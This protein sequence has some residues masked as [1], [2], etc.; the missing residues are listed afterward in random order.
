MSD[1]DLKAR[2]DELREADVRRTPRFE[3]VLARRRP[4]S[5]AWVLIPVGGLALVVALLLLFL[6]G[7]RESDVVVVRVGLREPEPLAFLLEPVR[8]PEETP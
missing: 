5:R 3:A 6:Q 2:F 8:L 7:P 1:D 4:P